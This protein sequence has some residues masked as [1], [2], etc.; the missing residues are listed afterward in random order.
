MKLNPENTKSK[1]EN[2]KF[3]WN[4]T[5]DFYFT[6]PLVLISAKFEIYPESI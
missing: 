6:N 5:F 1:D 2:E 4:L 3:D